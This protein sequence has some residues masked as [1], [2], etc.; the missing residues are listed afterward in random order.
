MLSTRSEYDNHLLD[1]ISRKE[2][3]DN[4]WANMARMQAEIQSYKDFIQFMAEESARMNNTSV[5]QTEQAS[6]GETARK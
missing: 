6:P 2:Y 3:W 1:P 4:I 5:V